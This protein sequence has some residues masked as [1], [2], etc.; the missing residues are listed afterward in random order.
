MRTTNCSI[1][2]IT[3]PI[4]CLIL[5]YLYDSLGLDG[6]LSSSSSI[7]FGAM[8]GS[9]MGQT[10][11]GTSVVSYFLILLFKWL[12]KSVLYRL[13]FILNCLLS[14]DSYYYDGMTY[15]ESNNYHYSSSEIVFVC[16][17]CKN[18]QCIKCILA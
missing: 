8:G 13:T 12:Q 6:N 16:D 14:I 1:T 4:F 17:I 11:R 15:C 10:G 3:L 2:K 5:H 18:I 7:N 9:P